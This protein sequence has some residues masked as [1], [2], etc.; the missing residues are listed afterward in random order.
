LDDVRAFAGDDYETAYVIPEA[1][2]VLARFDE[3]SAHYETVLTPAE[4]RCDGVP[5]HV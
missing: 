2:V 1:R 3:K 4:M 5:A